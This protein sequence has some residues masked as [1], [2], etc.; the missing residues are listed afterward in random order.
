MKLQFKNNENA[1]RLAKRMMFL[2]YEAC[3]GP[4]GMGIFQA[5]SNVTEEQVWINASNSGGVF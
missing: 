1:L 2:A 5:R 4:M 3:G